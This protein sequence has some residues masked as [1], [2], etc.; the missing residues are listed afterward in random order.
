MTERSGGVLFPPFEPDYS[1]RPGR[2]QAGG[3]IAPPLPSIASGLIRF[4]VSGIFI[5]LLGLGALPAWAQTAPARTPSP[6]TIA[7]PTPTP[8]PGGLLTQTA[9]AV[10]CPDA[11]PSRMV[12]GERGRVAIDDPRP[13]NI[14]SGAG[15]SNEIIGQIPARGIFVV[16]DG[17]RC[18]QR[19][20]WYQI[21]YRQDGQPVI[22]W[23]AE[24][25]AN[26]YFVDI[27]PP[28]W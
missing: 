22:G 23:I 26:A 19:Y 18:S 7:P 9:A 24:G 10:T 1:G 15:T 5:L 17:P 21:R 28:G 16:L 11:P 20:A 6:A 13:L 8:T 4:S 25:D 12:I 14:R 3:D 27:Y 2:T